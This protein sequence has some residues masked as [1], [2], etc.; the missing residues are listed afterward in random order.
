[1][2][3]GFVEEQ[4]GDA[5]MEQ[6]T[7]S[8]KGCQVQQ[9]H[10]SM[11]SLVGRDCVCS[12][13]SVDG[14]EY[15][16]WIGRL[17]GD[18]VYTPTDQASFV[19]GLISL[20]AYIL[21]LLPQLWHNFNRKSVE[22]LSFS[23]VLVWAVADMLNF[24]GTLLTHQLPIQ[25]TVSLYFLLTDFVSVGQY[26]WY[27]NVY[28]WTTSRRGQS[29][30]VQFAKG[31]GLRSGGSSAADLVAGEETPLLAS[32]RGS[33]Q[34]RRSPGLNKWIL[35]KTLLLGCGVTL[36]AAGFEDSLVAMDHLPLCDAKNVGR[37]AFI[38][39]ST[40]AWI[41]GLLYF[42]SRYVSFGCD[43]KKKA[44]T[45]PPTGSHKYWKTLE[46]SPSMDS[47]VPFSFAQF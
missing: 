40:T 27:E 16:P 9:V 28:P 25:R 34:H 35:S 37:V 46:K 17:F 30:R 47:L 29:R 5:Q 31:S 1:M 45:F 32:T 8:F 3:N 43:V 20:G 42:Y 41:S 18:C 21:S 38:F 36:V 24:M 2:Q 15:V 14:F 12:P 7:T 33:Q 6:N 44:L 11:E 26:L 23:L 13:L 10:K 39:G 4:E 19:L 22:G